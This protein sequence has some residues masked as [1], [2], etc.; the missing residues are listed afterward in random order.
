MFDVFDVFDVPLMPVLP[1]GLIKYDVLK[2]LRHV[3]Q[4]Q[5][6][7][8]RVT[9]DRIERIECYEDNAVLVTF[10]QVTQ[11]ITL[12]TSNPVRT[13]ILSG[14]EPHF[15][16]MRLIF[17][18]RVV[19]SFTIGHNIMLMFIHATR[20]LETVVFR[21][22]LHARRRRHTKACTAHVEYCGLAEVLFEVQARA[23]DA[24]IISK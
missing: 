1:S 23:C 24:D 10:A 21:F 7:K 15:T 13:E 8:V 17:T 20:K 14:G 12:D 9:L 16:C 19:W 5:I 3:C 11:T 2:R 6:Y 22:G 18:V 4:T